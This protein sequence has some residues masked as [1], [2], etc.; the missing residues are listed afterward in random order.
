VIDLFKPSYILNDLAE[1]FEIPATTIR[2]W[3]NTGSINIET[4]DRRGKGTYSFFAIRDVLKIMIAVEFYHLGL[5]PKVFSQFI[6]YIVLQIERKIL[7]IDKNTY[8]NLVN[9][10]DELER[11]EMIKDFDEP[12]KSAAIAALDLSVQI[13]DNNRFYTLYYKDN[14]IAITNQNDPNA[15]K[16]V[17]DCFEMARKA[18][19]LFST[20]S[21]RV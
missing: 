14:G 5:G 4:S 2:T 20:I 3:V 17:I 18:I 13:R 8:F 6:D 15:I 9:D 21:A 1:K 7:E 12:I 19:Q 11:R 16:I 10:N